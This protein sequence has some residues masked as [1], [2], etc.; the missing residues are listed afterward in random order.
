MTGTMTTFKKSFNR[1]PG[2]FIAPLILFAL[3]LFMQPAAAAED[4]N[5]HFDIHNARERQNRLIGEAMSKYQKGEIATKDELAKKINEIR[6][7]FGGPNDRRNAKVDSV[8]SGSE[9]DNSGSKPQTI[10]SDS[11][12]TLKT[13]DPAALDA[14]EARAR[15]KKYT[16]TRPHKYKIHIKELDATIW[17]QPPDVNDKAAFEEY[18]KTMANDPDAFPTA[19]GLESTSR[20]EP[21]SAGKFGVGDPEGA[22]LANVHK[23]NHAL[24]PDAKGNVDLHTAAKSLSKAAE[25]TGIKD[26]VKELKEKL[27][28][29]K[30]SN[31]PVEAKKIEKDIKNA[32]KSEFWKRVD[33]LRNHKTPAEAGIADPRDPPSKQKKDLDKFVA[34]MNEKLKQA[35]FEGARQGRERVSDLEKRMSDAEKS[36]DAERA[37]KARA[38]LDA[39]KTSNK[40]CKEVISKSNP[41]LKEHIKGVDEELDLRDKMNKDKKPGGGDGG[42]KSPAKTAPADT[43]GKTPADAGTPG[44]PVV[45]NAPP[46]KGA[47]GPNFE[48]PKPKTSSFGD[49]I[50]E[51]A[52]VILS[53][54][55]GGGDFSKI[56]KDEM[57]KAIKEGRDPDMIKVVILST[58]EIG[59]GEIVGAAVGWAGGFAGSYIAGAAGA[60]WGGPIA[61]GVFVGGMI[62]YEVGKNG[63]VDG[64]GNI[65]GLRPIA[66]LIYT[67]WEHEFLTEEQFKHLRDLAKDR[68]EKQIKE[69]REMK[70]LLK[71]GADPKKIADYKKLVE[72]TYRNYKNYIK[73]GGSP[74]DP[75]AKALRDAIEKAGDLNSIPQDIKHGDPTF[76]QADREEEDDE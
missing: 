47:F 75:T 42:E 22:A 13:S 35:H 12:A 14:I 61:V 10:A 67:D 52:M 41:E 9:A 63:L 69:I 34:E 29:A 20:A 2:V 17:V 70:K 49:S 23:A 54:L 73:M 56:I 3:A 18:V 25:V 6:S 33:D 31:D 55:Q 65:T 57:H 62:I 19:G 66:D 53:G 8:L 36:G 26:N 15:G 48:Q 44:K 28:K 51:G 68:A 71:L 58:W 38:D 43:G 24:K 37:K 39:V 5:E 60:A 11:D 76:I 46:K 59:K 30:K 50:K 16:V 45:K 40:I 74:D 32:E 1:L 21:G 4:P 7:E 27:D 72:K 64:L